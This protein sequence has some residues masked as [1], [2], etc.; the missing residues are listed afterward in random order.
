M[1]SHQRLAGQLVER[2]G[3]AFGEPPAVDEEQRRAVRANQLEQPRV[4]AAQIDVRTG[5]CDA[6]PLGISIGCASCAM[7]STGTSTRSSSGLGCA[8]VDDGDRPP[9]R[10]RSTDRELV[11][12]FTRGRPLRTGLV[13]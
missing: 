4:D 8:R 9:A 7:S 12:Q 2:R 5:P 3:Q 13:D 10:R 11:V 1:R 6:G